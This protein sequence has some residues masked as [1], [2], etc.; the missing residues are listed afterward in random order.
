[1]TA[2]API[3]RPPVN[4]ADYQDAA[5]YLASKG[6]GVLQLG[7]G[8]YTITQRLILGHRVILKGVGRGL[9]RLHILHASEPCVDLGGG[10]S[11]QEGGIVDLSVHSTGARSPGAPGILINGM[12]NGFIR[13]A[14]C[15]DQPVGLK[16]ISTGDAMTFLIDRF[17][18]N[19]VLEND[20]IGIDV[21]GA[22]GLRC[23]EIFLQGSGAEDLSNPNAPFVGL[24]ILNTHNTKFRALRSFH[25]KWGAVI[26]PG[27]GQ[28]ADILDF[29]ESIFEYCNNE[30]FLLNP[31]GTGRLARVKLRDCDFQFCGGNGLGIQASSGTPT[32]TGIAISNPTIVGNRQHGLRQTYGK[33]VHVEG[34]VIASNS[35][36]A[37]N[38][39][40][41]V[42]FGSGI[43]DLSVE[44][45]V[46][47]D[48][49]DLRDPAGNPVPVN[50]HKYDVEIES[51]AGSRIR[52]TENELRCWQTAPLFNGTTGATVVVSPNY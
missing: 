31:D 32:L 43:G 20:G 50:L 22:G 7:P 6:G 30:A 23:N 28:G 2:L 27:N 3:L 4:H 21:D 48:V 46:F 29:D 10:V 36:A 1:M 44:G 12:G 40:S 51:G 13:D 25:F 9:T 41:G 35:R 18:A 14:Y 49:F 16:A 34:G 19:V 24:R 39:Y 45:V 8:D 15:Y 17:G 42:S 11:A 38:T 37:A 52:V 33:H 26:S 5:N 47:D